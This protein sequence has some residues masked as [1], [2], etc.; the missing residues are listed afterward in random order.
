MTNPTTTPPTSAHIL[1]LL[2]DSALPLST[3]S[4]SSGLESHLQHHPTTPFSLH[5]FTTKS[6]Y[7]ASNLALPFVYAAYDVAS[8]NPENLAE[9]ILDL[10]DLLDASMLCP[11]QR[12]AS[13]SQGR[14]LGKIWEKVLA[15]IL[16]VP[17][18]EASST[19]CDGGVLIPPTPSTQPLP[20]IGTLHFPLG[21]A[22]VCQRSGISRE[23]TAW[24]FAWGLVKG[25]VSA[26]VRLNV[27]GPFAGQKCLVEV[28]G[29][30]RGNVERARGVRVEDCGAVW[31]NGEVVQGRQELLYSRVFNS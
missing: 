30:I 24:A 28:E 12:R 9:E 22:L 25:I 4:F 17:T 29:A 7:A 26:A 2:S 16:G 19:T 5:N 31:W 13:V 15:E 10:N 18:R 27:V 8:S 11:V 23:D 21:W 3:F 20:K 1:A 14:A 6:L